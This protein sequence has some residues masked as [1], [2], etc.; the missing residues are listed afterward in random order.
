MTT[1]LVTF[2]SIAQSAV[3]LHLSV[4]PG[5]IA[6]LVLNNSLP[7]MVLTEDAIMNCVWP[8]Q[9]SLLG[10][11]AALEAVTKTVKNDTI[12]SSLATLRLAYG[13]YHHTVMAYFGT[14][15]KIS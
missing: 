12:I 15:S 5:D 11:I 13:E 14:E 3:C 2:R 1:P 4:S 6:A 10:A 9:A 8:A 7:V